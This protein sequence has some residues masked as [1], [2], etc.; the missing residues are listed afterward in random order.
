LKGNS[1]ISNVTLE[2]IANL[3]KRRGFVLQA[4]EIYGG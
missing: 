3:A 2:N 4:S 1:K